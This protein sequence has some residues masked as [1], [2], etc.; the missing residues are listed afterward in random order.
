MNNVDLSQLDRNDR[1]PLLA[2]R[3]ESIELVTCQ[4]DGEIVA[5]WTDHR[6][7]ARMLLLARLS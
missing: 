3:T 2:A 6:R 7:A 5:V 1:D 4:C